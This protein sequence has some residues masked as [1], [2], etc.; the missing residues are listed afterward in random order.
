M[1]KEQS[2]RADEQEA[3]VSLM[4]TAS[5]PGSEPA[6]S[7]VAHEKLVSTVIT[8]GVC[9]TYTA[10]GPMLILLNKYLMSRGHFPY[11]ILLTCFGQISSCL[12]STILVRGFKVVPLTKMSWRFYVQNVMAVGLRVASTGADFRAR[13][14]S[15][16]SLLVASPAGTCREGRG[17]GLGSEKAGES[18]RR[19]YCCP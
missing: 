18:S 12:V 5:E 6:G 17:E 3:T 8:V 4:E 14:A 13:R 15:A 9:L 16:A 7:K 10:V 11:P 19:T 2:K 1:M